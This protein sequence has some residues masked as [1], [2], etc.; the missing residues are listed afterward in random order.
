VKHHIKTYSRTNPP[1][2]RNVGTNIA[3]VTVMVT[4]SSKGK[5][6][7]KNQNSNP[8]AWGHLVEVK[9]KCLSIRSDGGLWVVLAVTTCLVK[10]KRSR[11]PRAV[12][13]RNPSA[14]PTG[15]CQFLSSSSAT[16]AGDFA[17]FV[18]SL[19]QACIWELNCFDV[20]LTPY[21]RWKVSNRCGLMAS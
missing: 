10:R 14:S 15:G 19:A 3:Q 13:P 5:G 17:F 12:R 2:V 6:K 21:R 7:Y 1:P 11:K 16:T 8:S 9:S 20:T 18:T 4:R